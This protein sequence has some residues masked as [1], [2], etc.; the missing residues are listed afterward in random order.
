MLTGHYLMS[1][2]K[3]VTAIIIPITFENVFSISVFEG[4]LSS[5]KFGHLIL[6]ASTFKQWIFV[7]VALMSLPFII[8]S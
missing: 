7:I 1:L 8:L 6:Y 4:W 3:C 5:S 2:N